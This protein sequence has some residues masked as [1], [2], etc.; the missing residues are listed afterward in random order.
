MNARTEQRTEPASGDEPDRIAGDESDAFDVRL[1]NVTMRYGRAT[2][3]DQLNLDVKRGEFLSLLGPSG[4][5]KTTTLKLIAGFEQPTD[6]EI[7]IGGRSAAGLPPHKRDVNTVFQQYALFPH[8]SVLDNVAYG[9]KQRRVP[10]AKRRDQAADALELVGLRDRADTRPTALSGGQQ[11]RVALARALV[12]RPRV[13]L[14][15]EPLGALD[16]KLRQQMQIEL[17]RIHAEV[18]LTFVFVTH[19]QSEALSMSD[20]IAVMNHGKIE[21]LAEPQKIYDAPATPFVASFIGEMNRLRGVRRGDVAVVD[22]CGLRL[23]IASEVEHVDDGAAV[24]GVRPEDVSAVATT[25]DDAVGH[26]ETMMLTGHSLQLVIALRGGQSLVAVQN[27]YRDDV[28]SDTLRPGV[29]VSIDV[30]PSSVLL[31]GSD[32]SHQQETSDE[33]L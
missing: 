30:A 31:L 19:D 17:K 27:R 11:Q 10:K 1:S 3:I 21:Q 9:L 16:L 26:V 2:A 8:L 22:G 4:C 12:L 15:D 25:E 5:G 23:P 7:L 20:R 33:Q 24:I 28:R 6:G 18:G 29:A 13:L 32:S 14:L